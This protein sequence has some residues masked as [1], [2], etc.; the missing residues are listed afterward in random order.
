MLNRRQFTMGSAALLAACGLP[1]NAVLAQSDTAFDFD[2]VIAQA[3]KLAAQPYKA[4][5]TPDAAVLNQ[6]DYD[7]YQQVRFKAH[8]ALF[9]GNANALPV[10]LFFMGKLFQQPVAVF[11]VQNNKARAVEFSKDMFDIPSNHPAQQLKQGG[12]AGFRVMNDASGSRDWLAFLGAS[13]FRTAG[14]DDQYGLSARAIAIDTGLPTPEEFPRF[15]SFW[16]EPMADGITVYGLLEGESVAGAYKMVFNRDETLST[17]I[18]AHVFARR[19]INALGLAPLSSMYWY[20]ERD[21][22]TGIDWRPEIHDSDALVMHTGA[23]ER[24]CR[25]LQNPHRVTTSAFADNNPRGFGL[26]QRDR[27]FENYQ[28]D[29]VFYNKRP[30]VYIQPQGDWG[31]GAVHLLEIPTDDEI[32][33]NIALY[34]RPKTALAAGSSAVYRYTMHW[35]RTDPVVTGL[36]HVISTRVGRGGIPGHVRPAGVFKV[37]IDFDFGTAAP[38]R[39]RL[40]PVVT[41]PAPAVISNAYALP[42]EGQPSRARLVFDIAG[43]PRPEPTLVRAFLRDATGGA[44]TETCLLPFVPPVLNKG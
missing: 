1:L 17:H 38:E 37:S 9:A 42:V 32:H 41:A 7:A 20:G 19:T 28:D 27:N 23:G 29:G 30:S 43:A 26:V 36:G 11:A 14:V 25:P 35:A 13:Y 5:V 10:Q 15:S 18:E 6:I 12:F 44:L 21:R 22:N 16:L 40:Q 31:E 2:S 33:D 4:P 8:Q 24:I 34:W 39:T 3:K